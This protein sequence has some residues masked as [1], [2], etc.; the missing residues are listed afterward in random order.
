[1]MYVERVSIGSGCK[2]LQDAL[3]IFPLH[4]FFALFK[5]VEYHM[6]TLKFLTVSNSR[7]LNLL[8]AKLFGSPSQLTVPIS[9]DQ[10]KKW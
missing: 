8:V 4:C 5:L 2:L 9:Q 3:A 6:I 1:M 10:D 7:R